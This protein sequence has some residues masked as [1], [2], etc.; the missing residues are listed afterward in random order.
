[1]HKTDVHRVFMEI[2]F[3]MCYRIQKHSES[4]KTC[5][6]WTSELSQVKVIENTV[7]KDNW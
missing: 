7:I 4:L 3:I 2:Q 1:M 5:E 6:T